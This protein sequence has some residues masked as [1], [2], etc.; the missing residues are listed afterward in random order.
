MNADFLKTNDFKLIFR[1]HPRFSPEHC[2]SIDLEYD[3]IS[4]DNFT[5]ISD[6]IGDVSMHITFN[7]TS[8][9]EASMIGYLQFLLICIIK[10]FLD[11]HILI[12][13]LQMMFFK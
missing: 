9:F 2:P 1:Q 10:N 4:Y 8:V 5:P 3:F 6:L 7:S 11:K 12:R 13:F